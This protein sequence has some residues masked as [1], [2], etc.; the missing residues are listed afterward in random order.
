MGS[1]ECWRLGGNRI[2]SRPS[3]VG[4]VENHQVAAELADIVEA[5]VRVGAAKTT[6]GLWRVGLRRVF[7][8]P[9]R[10]LGAGLR[11][12]RAGAME[13]ALEIA[14][15]AIRS[16]FREGGNGEAGG[17]HCSDQDK[18]CSSEHRHSPG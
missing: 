4:S 13:G 3:W 18:L 16:V 5:R 14:A 15:G 11:T 10:T 1:I 2:A 9:R 8:V 17:S 7:A 6:H 12:D